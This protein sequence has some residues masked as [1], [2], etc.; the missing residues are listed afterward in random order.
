MIKAEKK[1]RFFGNEFSQSLLDNL[2][3]ILKLPYDL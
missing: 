3:A 1:L 2:Y